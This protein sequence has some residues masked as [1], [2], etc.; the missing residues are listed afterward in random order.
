MKTLFAILALIVLP[1]STAQAQQAYSASSVR[2]SSRSSTPANLQGASNEGV[3]NLNGNPTWKSSSTNNLML[4][5]PGCVANTQTSLLYYQPSPT[6]QIASMPYIFQTGGPAGNRVCDSTN[7]AFCWNLDPNFMAIGWHVGLSTFT[8]WRAEATPAIYG[9]VNGVLVL[10]DDGSSFTVNHT[11]H[12][13]S[14]GVEFPDGSTQTTSAFGPNAIFVD[15]TALAFATAATCDPTTAAQA[16]NTNLTTPVVS[17]AQVTTGIVFLPLVA[18]T[19]TGVTFQTESPAA[20]A[21][22]ILWAGKASNSSALA[23][24]TVALS[25]AG[26]Y[27]C[28]FSVP[29]GMTAGTTYMATVHTADQH[30]TTVTAC[31]SGTGFTNQPNAYG[32]SNASWAGPNIYWV[33]MATGTASGG[34]FTK[35]TTSSANLFPVKPNWTVP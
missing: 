5:C 27:V 29:F 13:T 14:G 15:P 10:E 4:N 16:Y 26:K 7:A 9:Y 22:C 35:P 20:S 23:T 8:G 30:A 31:S 2:F 12:T 3:F 17:P 28:N 25:G 34:G 11:I 21:D 32:G 33:T 24:G 1:L 6:Y 19:A 18:G